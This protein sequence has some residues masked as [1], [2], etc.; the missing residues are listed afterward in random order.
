MIALQ[1]REC[2]KLDFADSSLLEE[3]PHAVEVTD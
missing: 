3:G 2:V 1:T